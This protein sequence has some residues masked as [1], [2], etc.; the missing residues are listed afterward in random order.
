LVVLADDQA[1]FP[2]YDAVLLYRRQLPDELPA[3]WES[4]QR[5]EGR[6]SEDDMIAMNGQAVLQSQPFAQIAQGFVRFLMGGTGAAGPS[7][8]AS[9][10]DPANAAPTQGTDGAN[11]AAQAAG[12]ASAASAAATEAAQQGFATR[13]WQRLWAPD[14]WRLLAQHVMLVAISV[15][16]ATVMA[17]PL[18]IALFPRP[19]ARAL[20]LGAAGVLQTVPSLALLAVLIAALGIIGKWPA[21]IALTAYSVLP[22]LSNTC[23]GLGEVP[24]GVRHAAAALGMTRRQRLG[25]IEFPLALPTVLAGVRTATAIAIG[26][27]TIAAFIGAGGLGERIVTGLALNDSALLLAG[28]LP[29]A[30]LALL[31]EAVFELL[32][33]QIARRRRPPA[34]GMLM[35]A[36]SARSASAK[37]RNSRGPHPQ[38]ATAERDAR[39]ASAQRRAREAERAAHAVAQRELEAYERRQR[40]E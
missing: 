19:Q 34:A 7:G 17:V 15:G 5:L 13:F 4:L 8:A 25:Y 21:L 38:S 23:A 2:R 36:R 10:A 29:A 24:T 33:R 31:S 32:G 20:A 1:Y 30:G 16:L 26:T 22:I 27:A 35:P 39:A 18:G 11:S 28:A 14:L 9:D 37:R 6:I 40:G 12:P 3:T